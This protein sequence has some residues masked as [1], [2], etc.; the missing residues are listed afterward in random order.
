MSGMV[1]TLKWQKKIQSYPS[2]LTSW[3]SQHDSFILISFNQ[4]R[5]VVITFPTYFYITEEH[6]NISL[7]LRDVY[8]VH[9]LR[10]SNSILKSEICSCPS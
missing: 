5:T 2:R 1:T 7:K 6:I 9:F 4:R 8:T 3:I 10:G